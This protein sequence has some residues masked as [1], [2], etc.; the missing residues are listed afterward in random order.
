MIGQNPGVG[1][2]AKK[3]TSLQMTNDSTAQFVRFFHS[4]FGLLSSLGI[5]SF[6][7][8]VFWQLGQ[9]HSVTG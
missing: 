2:R 1:R 6:E 8:V 4:D 7:L 9:V 3:P 5:S